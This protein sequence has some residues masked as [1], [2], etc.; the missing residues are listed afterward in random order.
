[1]PPI[2]RSAALP[3][4]HKPMLPIT[5]TQDENYTPTVCC[6][7]GRVS[8]G[9]GVGFTGRPSGSYA[10]PQDPMYLCKLCINAAGELS[11]LQRL[12][13]YEL[14]AIDTGVAYVQAYFAT[15][16]LK[17]PVAF[18]DTK[19]LDA[20]M[21]AGGEWLG[22]HG[23]SDLTVLEPDQIRDFVRVIWEGCMAGLTG[24][25]DQDELTQRMMVKEAWAGCVDGVRAALR[26]GPF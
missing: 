8:L 19:A 26:E 9:I 6:A 18:T 12:S 25:E 1:M 22:T 4:T 10:P 15:L 17:R 3:G 24:I 11:N 13:T 23:V 7:C 16:G 2:P 5:P 21:A 20:G 14:K